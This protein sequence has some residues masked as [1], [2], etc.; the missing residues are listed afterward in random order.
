MRKIPALRVPMALF[1]LALLFLVAA[2]SSDDPTPTSAPAA[3]QP[4]AT[5]VPAGQPTATPD[6]VKYG[7]VLRVGHR[8]DPPSAWD[9][10]R[11]TNYNLTPL[12]SAL[13]GEGNLVQPCW[14][15]ERKIC[16]ALAES[17]EPN[18]DFSQWT[19]KIRKGVTW[20]DGVPFT[21][22]N[23]V[24]WV[25]LF[26]NGAK[27]GDK[28]RLPGA[29]KAQFG[30]F[31]K[32]ELVDADTVRIYLNNPN[33][34]YLDSLAKHRIPIFHAQHL[35][36]PAIAAGN[37]DVS[38]FELGNI[39]TGPFKFWT[40]EKSSFIAFTRNNEYWE[41]DSEGRQL[42]FLDGIEYYVLGSPSAHHAALRTGR[43]DV[44]A[45]G[46]KYY[47]TPELIPQFK[48]S[49]GDG[50]YFLER[51]GGGSA[52][53]GF[54]TMKAP[55]NDVR[56]R[57][58]ISLWVDR[59]TSVDTLLQ[60]YGR[61]RA[62]FLAT[63]HSSPDFMTWPGYDPKTKEADKA[64]ALQLVAAAGAEG[65]EFTIIAPNTQ[66][67][68]MEWWI[69][70]MDGLG[71]NPKLQ[72]MDVG[73]FDERKAGTDW[74]AT[75]GGGSLDEATSADV[76]FRF[77]R[78]SDSP[79]ASTVHEDPKLADFAVQMGKIST[80]EER[81]K[82]LQEIEQYVLNEQYYMLFNSVGLSLVPVRS[83]VKDAKM[84]FILNPPTYASYAHTW[85][86]Q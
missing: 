22:E 74:E 50:V 63:E 21:A 51:A 35:F 56:L 53:I 54:N 67:T 64:K 44:G 72:I 47:A 86:D 65:L 7:G 13:A 8:K 70:A 38:P 33:S 71:M 27:V 39:G 42:P 82:L 60:G 37:V 23:V 12:T 19:F 10:M 2:C 40:Y 32:I 28:E 24:Y 17:W 48:E 6:P 76:T 75:W 45:R 69:G 49:L 46:N 18:A 31:D 41:K 11:S 1:A 66:T 79:Y 26:V 29:A 59:Q 73:A 43:L 58:A 14:E 77:G 84:S 80:A 20:H 68:A 52:A 62:G 5:S 30:D 34:F 78:K 83:Y 85:L 57:E 3:A 25:N 36:E 4:T 9:T 61:V 15:D 55:F 16:P 81:S